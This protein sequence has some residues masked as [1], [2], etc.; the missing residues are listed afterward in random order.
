MDLGTAFAFACARRPDAEAFVEGGRR[1]SYAAWLNEIRA[2]AGGL[3]QR[4][5]GASDRLVV[6]MRNRY[7]MA[8]LYWA[9]HLLGLVFT[10]VSFRASSEEIAYC[11]DDAETKAVAYDGATGDAVPQAAAKLGI[12]PRRVIVAA[13]G[14]GAGLRF[15]NLLAAQPVD[16]PVGVDDRAICLMLYTS[17]TTGRPKGVP[18]SH[19]AELMA[20]VSQI[21]H[22]HYRPG[23]SSLGVMP[24]FHT[25]GVRT[26][27][28]SALVNGKVV[29]MSDYA[30]EEV[31]RLT[32]QEKISALFLVPTMFHDILREPKFE[33][34][35]LRGV[36]RASYAGMAMT[37]A[38]VEKCLAM[39]RPKVFVNHYG[40]S[41][42]YTFTICD[43]PR[44]AGC[45]GRA[46]LN[47]RIRV[48]SA[49]AARRDDIATDLPPGET[50]EIVASMRSPEAFSGYWK[51]PDADAKSIQGIWYRTGDLG[52]FDQDGELYVVGRVDDM[53]VSAGENIFPEEV[54]DALARSS[55]VAG[56]AVVGMPDERLGARV[57]AFVEPSGD[58]PSSAQLDE[59]CLRRG[60]ARF[61]RPREYVMVKSIPRSASGKILRRRLRIGD[62]QKF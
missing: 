17:G 35:D 10:P 33:S 4:G 40:S 7:E 3:R 12:D 51:R 41:E 52:K 28:S 36:S 6:V 37:P 57:V 24:M 49:D 62:Y 14:A 16:G 29:C 58:A 11:L 56:V 27:L 54:E 19:R 61:K 47:Q 1:C 39:L 8:T 15:D 42:I 20:A 5:L 34:F 46:G 55:L 26:L 23:E 2:V 9:S 22:H 43:H 18:R 45:A 32:A 31:L 44:K 59:A 21:A 60:L 13:D 50:G 25:M 48:V 38:L 53:I 30:P